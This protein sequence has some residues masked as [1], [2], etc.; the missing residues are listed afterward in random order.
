VI[1]FS[2]LAG[3]YDELRPAGAGWMEVAEESLRML[4]QPARLL[5]VGCGTGRYAELASGRLG[6]RVW[7]IDP[8]QEMLAQARRREGAGRVGWKLAEAEHLPF[9]DGWFDAAHAHLVLHALRDRP[10]AYRELARVLQ[11]GGRAVFASFRPEHFQGF[12]LNRYF[13]SIPVID[14]ERFPDPVAVA[15]ELT[16]AGFGDVQVTAIDQPVAPEPAELLERVRGRYIST[17]H[18]V[19]DAEY[20][21]G[22]ALLER[23]L[24]DGVRPAGTLRWALIGGRRR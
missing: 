14:G 16:A 24:A 23:E 10:A 12:Y 6:A 15:G 3:R 1:D 5:D 21:K 8:S 22:V 17:L 4:G 19:P 2:A 11:P 7:G 18:L 20:A 13:P 9:K